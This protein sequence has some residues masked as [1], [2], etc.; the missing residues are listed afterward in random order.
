[1]KIANILTG[2]AFAASIACAQS[3]PEMMNVTH[4]MH[5]ASGGITASAPDS[6]ISR[7]VSVVPAPAPVQT[8][9]VPSGIVYTCDPN[10]A[11]IMNGAVCNTL[12]TT[13]AALY[14]AAFANA[15]AN[16]YVQLGS[17]SLGSSY[18][19]QYSISYTSFRNALQSSATDADDLTAF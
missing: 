10:L 15:N 2:C 16:I 3:A 9:T 12:N 14:S 18:Y 11:A 17:T 6:M 13:I 4:V 19:L 8:R 5:P 7:R 1:M